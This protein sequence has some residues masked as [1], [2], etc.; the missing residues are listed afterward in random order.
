LIPTI[1]LNFSAWSFAACPMS[2]ER[3]KN[4]NSGFK[5]ELISSNSFVSSW[6]KALLPAESTIIRLTAS[7]FKKSSPS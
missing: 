7:F 6:S 2:A 5:I 4:E 3:T 1:W